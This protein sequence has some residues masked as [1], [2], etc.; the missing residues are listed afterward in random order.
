VWLKRA[1]NERIHRRGT[2]GTFD[3]PMRRAALIEQS[4]VN[5]A[6]RDKPDRLVVD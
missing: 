6:F 2:P 3:K 4:R 5:R 1:S